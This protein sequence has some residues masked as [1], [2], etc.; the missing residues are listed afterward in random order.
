MLVSAKLSI[1]K[2]N[3]DK[4]SQQTYAIAAFVKGEPHVTAVTRQKAIR[5]SEL[6]EEFEETAVCNQMKTFLQAANDKNQMTIF[7]FLTS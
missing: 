5:L 2:R 3:A 4:Q 6:W 7:N 1:A